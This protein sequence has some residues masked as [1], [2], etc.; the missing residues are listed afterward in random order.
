MSD[1]P[2]GEGDPYADLRQPGRVCEHEKLQRQCDLCFALRDVE[3][4]RA[5]IGPPPADAIW[6]DEPILKKHRE[7]LDGLTRFGE[8]L[9]ATITQTKEPT[10]TTPQVEWKLIADTRDELRAIGVTLID[11]C[12]RNGRITRCRASDVL[13]EYP[14][15]AAYKVAHWTIIPR[16][17]RAPTREELVERV[18]KEAVDA[19]ERGPTLPD[20]VRIATGALIA[21]DKRAKGGRP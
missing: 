21:H 4:L 15:N 16:P 17:A 3:L 7:V 6:D 12:L 13:D 10:V 5:R 19:Y 18:V 9:A 20:N 8:E 1:Q 2:F 11:V 14:H